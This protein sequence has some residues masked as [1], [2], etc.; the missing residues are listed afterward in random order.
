MGSLHVSVVAGEFNPVLSIGDKAPAW[1]KLPGV[2]D[3]AIS[4]DDLKHKDIVVLVFTCNTCPYA[5]DVEDRLVALV[6]KYA[7][8]SFALVAINVNKVE[9]D[10]MPAMKKRAEEKGF[11][12]PYLYDETQQTAR[13]YGASRTPEFF[14]LNKDRQIVYMGALDDSPDGKQVSKKYVEA[15]IEA[16]IKKEKLAIGETIPI[17]CNIRFEQK[18]R[19]Q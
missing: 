15:A 6:E 8:H 3:K 19:R 13:D 1:N 4:L 2:D 7:K 9:S 12:F 14:V 17:G 16:T 10:A 18:R 11:S 5:V